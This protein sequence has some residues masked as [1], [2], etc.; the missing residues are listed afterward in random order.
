MYQNRIYICLNEY[1][2]E[3]G[4]TYKMAAAKKLLRLNCNSGS[5]MCFGDITKYVTKFDGKYFKEEW[6]KS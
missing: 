5:I 1:D 4:R 6:R 3:I 2:V